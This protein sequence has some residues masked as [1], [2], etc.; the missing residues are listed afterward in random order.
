MSAKIKVWILLLLAPALMFAQSKYDG[1]KYLRAIEYGDS[2]WNKIALDNTLLKH[3][4][5]NQSDLRVIHITEADDTLEAPYIIDFAGKKLEPSN[6]A[7]YHFLPSVNDFVAKESPRYQTVVLEMTPD[8]NGKISPFDRVQLN[9]DESNFHWKIQVFGSNKLGDWQMLNSKAQVVDLHNEFMDYRY[10]TVHFGETDFRYIALVFEMA[11]KPK[12]L[13][14]PVAES[15]KMRF[16]V[17]KTTISEFKQ[18]EEGQLTRIEINFD[19]TISLSEFYF[20]F[21]DTV[22][23]FREAYLERLTGFVKSEKGDIPQYEHI[24]NKTVSSLEPNHFTFENRLAKSLRL[25]IVN[26]NDLPLTFK[27]G[28]AVAPKKELIYRSVGKGQYFLI[29]GNNS[30]SAPRYDMVAFKDKIPGNISERVLGAEEIIS[31]SITNKNEPVSNLWIWIIMVP[32]IG[33]MGWF[34]IKMLGEKTS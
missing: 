33:L 14:T 29:Y 23:F 25:T 16:K 8:S 17:T 7:N 12:L 10:T 15:G 26:R 21:S 20:D 18:T 34:S 4:K 13:E 2:T 22:D 30:A 19:D 24:T 28:E 32:A 5:T 31:V 9:I 27:N 6:V 11:Y 1:F 3:C